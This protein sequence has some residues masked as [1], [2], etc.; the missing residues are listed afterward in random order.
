MLQRALA[1]EPH[2]QAEPFPAQGTHAP[3]TPGHPQP[4]ALHVEDLHALGQMPAGEAMSELLAGVRRQPDG[5]IGVLEER[6]DGGD[7]VGAWQF[8]RV[9]HCGHAVANPRRV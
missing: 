2:G 4:A 7:A 1:A 9:D 5:H 6:G 8:S 3:R